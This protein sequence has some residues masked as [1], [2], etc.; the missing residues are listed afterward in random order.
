MRLRWG[1]PGRIAART[2]GGGSWG[3]CVGTGRTGDAVQATGFAHVAV[4]PWCR[5]RSSR[6]SS[7]PPGPPPRG[8]L[9]VRAR[10]GSATGSSLDSATAGTTS[11][12]TTFACDSRRPTRSSP[13]TATRRSRRG[14]RSRCPGLTWT[15]PAT[16]SGA[17]PSTAPRPC[18]PRRDRS[19]SSHP[20][21]RSRRAMS[22]RSRSTASW[23]PRRPSAASSARRRSSSPRT[24]R[25]WRPSR[26]TRTSCS[27]ATTTRA[28]WR[29]S[30]SRSTCRQER[31]P[32]RTA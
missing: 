16:P 31:R 24:A 29:R 25:P 5:P 4:E 21:T 7:W 14:P 23:R 12:T 6:R 26:T 9:R 19:W 30:P 27:R 2:R 22:S 10:R 32:S 17:C 8:T 28:T 15:G 18:S 3:G 13:C 1:A 11:C 20:T